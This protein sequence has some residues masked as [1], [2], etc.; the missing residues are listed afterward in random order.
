MLSPIRHAALCTSN[1]TYRLAV[2]TIHHKVPQD[3]KK[4]VSQPTKDLQTSSAKKALMC[5]ESLDQSFN[6]FETSYRSKTTG[7]LIRALGV[8]RLCSLNFLV[9]HNKEVSIMLSCSYNLHL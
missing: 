1:V 3:D 6:D 5:P 7:E 2:S 8:F 9:D 4:I